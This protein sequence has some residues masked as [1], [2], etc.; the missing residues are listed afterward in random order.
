MVECQKCGAWFRDNYHLSR[1]QSRVKPCIGK[2]KIDT[3]AKNTLEEQNKLLKEQNE[4]LKEQNKLSEEQKTPL[5]VCKFCLN[6][7]FNISSLKRHNSTCKLKNDPVRLLEI[8]NGITPKIPEL[9]TECRFCNKVLFNTSKLNSHLLICKEREEYHNRLLNMEQ[10]QIPTQIN[11][12]QNQTNIEN[13]TNN[14]NIFILSFGNEN[15][16]NIRIEDIMKDVNNLISDN[17]DA[18]NYIIA[19]KLLT[20]FEERVKENPANK[21]TKLRSI[22]SKYGEIKTDKGMKK[23]KIEKFLDNCIKNTAKNFNKKK[24][25]LKTKD[26]EQRMIFNQV[27]TYAKI[28]FKIPEKSVLTNLDIDDESKD[29]LIE[30]L[31]QKDLKKEIKENTLDYNYT[32]INES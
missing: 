20:C 25:E 26:K 2:N 29:E 27:D 30:I 13:Q 17:A 8:E 4:L 18:K 24:S 22:D 5:N 12:I 23:V 15:L 21:N 28:G 7:F 9:K 10:K 14:Q 11:N 6:T 3:T 32:I 16:D 1:H 19:G 31:E